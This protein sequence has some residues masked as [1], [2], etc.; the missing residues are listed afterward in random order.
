MKQKPSFS[1]PGHENEKSQKIYELKIRCVHAISPEWTEY[2]V[3]H[4]VKALD[5]FP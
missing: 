2:D 1:Y 4:K 3:T 5:G